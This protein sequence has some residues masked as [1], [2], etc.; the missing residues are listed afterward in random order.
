MSIWYL[1]RR[2]I[3]EVLLI[4]TL[5]GGVSDDFLGH[6]NHVTN[7]FFSTNEPVDD[8]VMRSSGKRSHVSKHIIIYVVKS[9]TSSLKQI[10]L[11]CCTNVLWWVHSFSIYVCIFCCI[12][13]HE[14]LSANNKRK[15]C[16]ILIH[17]VICKIF[18]YSKFSFLD[19]PTFGS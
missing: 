8:D 19:S 10:I 7:I 17:R 14:F 1:V 4:F 13:C 11:L 16:M 18:Y 9:E 5:G 2:C 6:V 3:K 15:R 12:I